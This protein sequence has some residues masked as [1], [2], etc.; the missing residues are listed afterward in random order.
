MNQSTPSALLEQQHRRIDEG[1]KAA[2]KGTAPR[3]VLVEA[4]L[5]LREH[6]HLEEAVLFPPLERAGLT[7]PIFVMQREHGQ[8]WPLI[9]AL[10]D[11]GDDAR[12]QGAGRE[13]FQM[14]QIHNPK[15]EQILYRAADELAQRDDGALI[16]ALQA[17][18]MPAGWVCAMAPR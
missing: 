12:W 18:Q 4:L 15:E 3:A 5:L 16:Q 8:M 6:I 14:L 13:L 1:I 9:Q 11:A 17:A 2:L 7:M 10:T